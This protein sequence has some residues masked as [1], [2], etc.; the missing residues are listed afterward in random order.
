MPFRLRPLLP[1]LALA[2][3]FGGCDSGSPDDG[4]VDFD[5][6]FAPPTDDE[7]AAVR[8]EWDA[9]TV[10]GSYDAGSVSVRYDD[11]LLE[12]GS[13]VLIIEH[14]TGASSAAHFGAVRV[15]AGGG[16]FPVIVAHH[17][18]DQGL[19]LMQHL[20]IVGGG[21][22][23]PMAGLGNAA[24]V[25]FPTYRAESMRSTPLGEL[26]AGGSASPWDRDVDDSL[27][28]LNAV[29][30]VLPDLADASRVGTVGFSRGGG[31]ALLMAARPL[32]AGTPYTIR[33]V[34]EYFG[35]TDLFSPSFRSLAESVTYM[36]GTIYEQLPGVIYLKNN[37]LRPLRFGE[38]TYEEARLAALR[39]SASYFASDLPHTQAHHHRRDGVV[40]FEQFESLQER[41]GAISGQTQFFAYGSAGTPSP[42]YHSI[43][44]SILPGHI[45]RTAAFLMQHVVG[46]PAAR[47][48]PAGPHAWSFAE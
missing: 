46:S 30:E 37:V 28:L 19:D 36:D 26:V 17:G 25:V 39:R 1:L 33:A 20:A 9:R 47:L 27:A 5:R 41:S 18:G 16:P 32:P 24:I 34:T 35:P 7:R 13:R 38:I 21:E 31:V 44:E 42:Q 11:D 14:T 15:P 40:P 43:D 29:F 12:D 6:L 4:Q 48:A 23:A 22:D 2:L 45:E 10:D 8:A 3:L